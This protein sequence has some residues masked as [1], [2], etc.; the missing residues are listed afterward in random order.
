MKLRSGRVWLGVCGLVTVTGLAPFLRADVDDEIRLF[1][2]LFLSGGR[3]IEGTI[4]SAGDL[5]TAEK[6]LVQTR[7]GRGQFEL[8]TKDIERIVRRRTVEEVYKSKQERVAAI[9]DESERANAYAE[10]AR[11][12]RAP[13]IELDGQPPRAEK[14]LEHFLAALE[15]DPTQRD[16]YAFVLDELSATGSLDE[17][18]AERIET[19]LLV[20]ELA[21]RGG[22]DLPEVV[23]RRGY[24]IATHGQSKNK[25]VADFRRVLAS[26]YDNRA[27]RR[28]ARKLLSEALVE[29]GDRAGARRVFEEILVEPAT[30]PSNFEALYELGRLSAGDADPAVRGRAK[31][32]LEQ[33]RAIQ[34]EFAPIYELL[35]AL[36]FESGN[37][38]DAMKHLKE[39]IAKDPSRIGP[40][41]NLAVVQAAGGLRS[42]ATKSLAMILGQSAGADRAAAHAALGRIKEDAGDLAGAITE[43]R[44]AVAADESFVDA[45]LALGAALA[46]A[47]E[48]DEARLVASALLTANRD[49]PGV[50]VAGTRILAEAELAA[51]QISTATAHL[52]RAL[53]L[54]PED[55]HLRERLGLV[56]IRQGNLD[57]AYRH[58]GALGSLEERPSAQ[59]ALGYYHYSRGEL[60]EAA[61]Q[62]KLVEKLTRAQKA[63]DKK[64]RAR[65]ALFAYAQASL[66]QLRDLAELEIWRAEFAGDDAPRVDGWTEV[67]RFGIA[68]SRA[69]G[70]MLFAGTQ[71]E[72]ADGVT[73]AQLDRTAESAS[74]DRVSMRGAV[75][76]GRVRFGLRMEG[77]TQRGASTG[78]LVHRDFDG[79]VRILVKG[80]RGS[81]KP[82][83]PTEPEEEDGKDES[84]TR[85]RTSRRALVYPGTVSWPNDSASRRLEIRRSPEPKLGTSSRATKDT[86]DV[87]LDGEN[88]ASFV[89]V[90]GLSR[91]K[92]RFSI[93]AQTDAEGN[94]FSVS[95]DEFHLYRKQPRAK[96]RSRY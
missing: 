49:D 94:E 93:S 63:S 57:E 61:I 85:R 43:Y 3:K 68:I 12:C 62:F 37:H 32:L 29:A 16:L 42:T 22:L 83:E 9:G 34:P 27:H 76:S 87:V 60:A 59:A 6:I 26:D 50:F 14:A 44:A 38:R 5:E 69:G 41:V 28:T 4:L 78:I 74:F 30:D 24:I 81:W 80:T 73:L 90:S 2:T 66:A 86:F 10:L 53:A 48:A 64:D 35:G 31:A 18:S 52:E 88:V 58:L 95:V 25:A 11:W 89:P 17:A 36:E 46:R 77:E 45:Q 65:M 47:G 51:G 70:R 84:S 55:A 40:Q 75:H 23:F 54:R 21:Q 96:R 19:E 82:L 72:E 71:R 1:D 39:A 8:A 15:I 91:A 20:A 92:L 79:T 67:E 7:S 33:A 56:L 13:R